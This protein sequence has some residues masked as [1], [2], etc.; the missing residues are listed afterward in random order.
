MG[1]LST[2][3][4]KAKSTL[5]N[6]A[7]SGS[8]L[9]NNV[10][11]AAQNTAKKVQQNVQKTANN[12][13]KNVQKTVSNAQKQVQNTAK[14]VQK[15]VQT[16]AKNV[17]KTV[18]TAAK[19]TAQAVK[20]NPTKALAVAA[21]PAAGLG[22]VTSSLVAPNLLSSAQNTVNN[23][24]Q[25]IS[26]GVSGIG[27]SVSNAISTAVSTRDASYDQAFKDAE[28][29]NIAGG[30]ARGAVTAAADTLLP[31]D[32]LNV[33]NKLITGQSISGE[34]W[35]YAGVDA[36]AAV[37]GALSGGLGYVGIKAGAKAI[38]TGV[39]AGGTSM[40][41]LSK[42]A[43]NVSTAKSTSASKKHYNNLVRTQEKRLQA[44]QAV[45]NANKIAA[46]QRG[47]AAAKAQK[48]A[49]L[50]TLKQ[51]K[52][53]S[54]LA[55]ASSGGST[56]TKAAKASNT[57]STLTKA[58]KSTAKTALIGGGIGAALVGIPTIISGVTGAID[59]SYNSGYEDGYAEGSSLWD[60]GIGDMGLG[61]M[62]LGDMGLDEGLYD[63]SGFL[64]D[65]GTWADGVMEDISDVP[66][67]GS[68]AEQIQANGLS[69]PVLVLGAI[70]ICAGGYFLIKKFSKKGKK[71]G[72]KKRK[73]TAKKTTKG[74][75]AA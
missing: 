30:V 65:A 12:V 48:N 57:G 27:A 4:S 6:A 24:A 16:T 23:A 51:T 54:T 66:V 26:S 13:Q 7:K 35:L 21:M 63:D 53:A 36:V 73:S 37:A 28:S 58:T 50:N 60:T 14:N 75:V 71:T 70:V 40:G 72:T 22:I 74:G 29:G 45:N 15:N 42:F 17:Q 61:D 64:E 59:D 44:A 9:V 25:T 47:L 20:A 67:V 38:K 31:L 39:K 56:V 19:N 10:T 43:K 52:Q 5:Q 55:K 62:G 18:T 11:K 49:Y 41:L 34:E 33:G 1:L 3:A 2:I 68:L 8:T 32:A 46:A 69:L